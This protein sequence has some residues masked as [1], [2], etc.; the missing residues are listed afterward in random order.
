MAQVQEQTVVIRLSK[1]VKTNTGASLGPKGFA[2]HLEAIVTE[3]IDDASIIVEVDDEADH[4][5]KQD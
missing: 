3:L 5:V 2:D 4:G 1:L